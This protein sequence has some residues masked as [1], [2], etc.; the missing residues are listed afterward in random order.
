M[1]N[2]KCLEDFSAGGHSYLKDQL[3]P[4]EHAKDWPAGSLKRRL[5]NGF[6][7]FDAPEDHD[8]EQDED[9]ETTLKKLKGKKQQAPG[10]VSQA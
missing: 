4:V 10:T 1:D 2:F 9:T 3:I 5:A 8:L 7:E 6:I